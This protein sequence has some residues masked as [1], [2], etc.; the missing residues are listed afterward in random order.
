MAAKRA[1]FLA[2]VRPWAFPEMVKPHLNKK[3][4]HVLDHRGGVTGAR[5]W[6]R[7]KDILGSSG[8]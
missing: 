4:S 1:L 5:G 6:R 7:S 3:G 8:L 2:R